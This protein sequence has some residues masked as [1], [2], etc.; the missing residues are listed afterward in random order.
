MAIVVLVVVIFLFENLREKRSV[1]LTKLHVLKILVAHQHAVAHQRAA[2]HQVETAAAEAV[3]R[4]LS[5]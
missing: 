3:G 5:G 1:P 2:A 4:S